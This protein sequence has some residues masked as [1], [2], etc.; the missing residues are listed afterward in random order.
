LEP[1]GAAS[2]G[3]LGANKAT[4]PI[5]ANPL[6]GAYSRWLS[7]ASRLVQMP[8][9]KLG[10]FDI[11]ELNLGAAFGLPG[12]QDMDVVACLAKLSRW[13]DLVRVNTDHWW[14]RFARSPGEFDNSPSQ[15][16]MLVLVTVLQRHLGVRYNLAF[17][18]GDYNGS[19]SRNLFIHGLLSGYGGTCVSMPVLYVAVGRR[20]GYPLK[21]ANAKEHLFA[22]WEEPGGERFN[23]ESTSRGFSVR[24]DEFY[25]KWPKPITDEEVERGLYL[26]SLRPREE[27]AEFFCHRGNCLRDNMAFLEASRAYSHAAQLSPVDTVIQNNWAVATALH[28]AIQNAQ[29]RVGAEGYPQIELR[30]LEIPDLP[31]G[32]NVIVPYVRKELDRIAKIHLEKTRRNARSDAFAKI[33]ASEGNGGKFVDEAF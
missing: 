25:R 28:L 3:R 32:W 8:D 20:L 17:M 15:F 31:N 18:D 7:I 26:R 33:N 5:A 22:R 1:A 27:L 2:T 12:A 6:E 9:E 14:Q 23:I 13:T 30:N 10:A 19:D 4:R 29:K 16:R 24:D 21:L 11:A